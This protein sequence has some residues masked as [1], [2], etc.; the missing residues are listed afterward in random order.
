M[1]RN[2]AQSGS[3]PTRLSCL[4]A[5]AANPA[6]ADRL[7]FVWF[8]Y[9]QG[10]QLCDLPAPLASA[11]LLTLHD[12]VELWLDLA[13]D[14]AGVTVRNN[15]SLATTGRLP[16]THHRPTRQHHLHRHHQPRPTRGGPKTLLRLIAAMAKPRRRPSRPTQRPPTSPPSPRR[17]RR[18]H[19]PAVLHPAPPSRPDSR[20][21]PHHDE[22]PGHVAPPP[23]GPT[24]TSLT[25]PLRQ[26][27]VPHAVAGQ[28]LRRRLGC[29]SRHLRRRRPQQ[30]CLA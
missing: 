5:L 14:H 13:V 4:T 17:P 19:R 1:L 29:R 21:R 18:R 26:F 24:T 28:V 16:T 2:S 25:S 10:Q 9:D 23:A 3:H 15:P 6:T 11:G 7:A 8:L 27:E 12:A 22:V 30:S 20:N